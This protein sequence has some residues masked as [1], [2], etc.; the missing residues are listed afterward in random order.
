M[1]TVHDEPVPLQ[2]APLQPL[3]VEPFVDVAVRVTVVPVA[4]SAAQLPGHAIPLGL[5]VTVPVPLPTRFTVSRSVEAATLKRAVTVALLVTEQG[6]VPE[7][8]P[9]LQ[10][11]NV[12]PGSAAALSDTVIPS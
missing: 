12:E 2:P 8:P 3:N 7:Q 1:A 9:P 5:L 4:K 11:A 10:P 6:P